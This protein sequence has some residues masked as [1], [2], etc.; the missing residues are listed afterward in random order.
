MVYHALKLAALPQRA[1]DSPSGFEIAFEVNKLLR[2]MPPSQIL[3]ATSVTGLV[4]EGSPSK[5]AV[6]THL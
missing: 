4:V 3:F 5:L 2:T 1:E 6:D